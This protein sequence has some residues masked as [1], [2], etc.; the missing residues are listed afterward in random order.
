MFKSYNARYKFLHELISFISIKLVS[1]TNR[2]GYLAPMSSVM[3]KIIILSGLCF[4]LCL[5]CLT[6]KFPTMHKNLRS[7]SYR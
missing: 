1:G 7:F 5:K 4:I 3:I 2:M 6:K